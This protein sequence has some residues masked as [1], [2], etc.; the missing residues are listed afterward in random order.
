[1]VLKKR[2]AQLKGLGLSLLKV[3]KELQGEGLRVKVERQHKGH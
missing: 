1:M 3:Q 2:G